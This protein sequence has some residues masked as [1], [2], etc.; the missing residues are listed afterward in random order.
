MPQVFNDPEAI[1]D[2]IIRDV[3]RKLVVGLPLGLG[4]ANHIVNALYARAAADR[5]IDLTF[6]SALTLE[7]PKPGNLLESRFITPVIDRLFGG[8]PDLA[9]A[10][11]LRHGKLPPNIRVIEFF[12][13]AG[14]WLRVPAAQQNYISAN[15][16]HAASYLLTSGL[17]VVTQLVAK[18][19]VDGVPR[20]S[21]SC[22][23]DTT[24]DV[25]RA[26]SEGRA[27][28][29][30][31]A[32]VNSEL[33]FMPGPG[34]LPGDTFSAVLDSPATEFPLFA[35]PSEPISDAKYAIG[36]HAAGLVRD[37]GSLQIGI[38][39]V[40]DALAQG[41]VVRHRDNARFR[42]IMTRLAPGRAPADTGPFDKGLYGVSEMVTEAFIGLI[43]ARILK[44]AVDGI[45]LHGAFFLG[46]KSFYRVLREM[47]AADIARIRMMPVSFTNELYGDEETKR[48]ARVDARFVNSTM[49]A[50]LLGAAVSDGLDNG[51]VVSGV[52]GQY[53]FVAQAFA[54]SGARSLL[55]L[56][57]TR[58][59]GGKAQSN[60]RWNYGHE[61][62]PRHLRDVFITEYGV[63]DVRGKSDADVIA[64]MLAI[65][66]SRF[67]S[68]LAR[69][70]KE[71]GKL[72][73]AHEIPAA[74]R[75]NMPER[76]AAALKPARD[77]GLLPSFPFGSDFTE[78]EQRLIPALEILQDA[79]HAPLHL[80]RLLWG[81][82][83]RTPGAAD[84]ECLARLGLDRPKTFAE[85]AYH[86]L[87]SA[88][89]EESRAG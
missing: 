43:D 83:T 73:R 34:D 71:A 65:T 10:E 79:Q 22:N 48:A 53:N 6:F 1:A 37:G 72:P 12:F 66:D 26:R 36:L 45:I 20:Y 62:I 11:P 15:Y 58:Q 30:L 42:E 77:A 89:L 85:R 64:A 70:A 57:A 82:W 5:S 44:R 39:Q 32:Q 80:A 24:L 7:K 81:G 19:V 14:R 25:L 78:V 56:E 35:P 68:E 75:E 55:A 54:L 4:K 59:S 27:N 28:F 41:L 49:M 29:R 87:V 67:Q 76:I 33:P 3:G 50:T 69:V 86:A 40:G 74:Y 47:G 31:V 61:T 9:Y 84:E 21:L 52:G 51:Q 17:N 13:L 46:P 63:A 16:T 88:A 2:D 18:R 23:T 8:Y 60:I 38:G